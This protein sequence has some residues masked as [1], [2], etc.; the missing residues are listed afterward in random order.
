MATNEERIR[1]CV[2]THPNWD[3]A[4][5]ANALKIT[6]SET[7]KLMAK[8]KLVDTVNPTDEKTPVGVSAKDMLGRYD[9]GTRLM[10][11]ISR[12]CKGKFVL[13]ADIRTESGIPIGVYRRVAELEEFNDFRI[14]DGDKLYWSMPDNVKAVRERQRAWGI[15]R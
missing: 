3:N 9:Y 12:M 2:A 7:A 15:T 13:D 6:V 4:R 10:D 14:K 11:T 5:R 1:K 8:L